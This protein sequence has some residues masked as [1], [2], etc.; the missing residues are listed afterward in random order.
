MNTRAKWRWSEAGAV[1]TAGTAAATI[2]CCLPFASGVVGASV[3]AAGARVAPIR[4]HLVVLSVAFLGYAF[5]Q[6]YRRK[7][8]DCNDESCDTPITLSRRR[9]AFWV[10]AVLVASLLTASW[11][12]NWIIY[13]T[14]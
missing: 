14:L 12:V 7:P 1:T 5:Y 13:W 6:V 3:A 8:A 10:I 2:F 9:L 11:W 4:S